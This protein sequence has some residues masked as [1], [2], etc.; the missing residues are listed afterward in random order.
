MGA[1]LL[2]LAKSIYAR[3]VFDITVRSHLQLRRFLYVKICNYSPCGVDSNYL[4]VSVK[5]TR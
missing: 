3:D 2:A 5:I 4:P 1:S